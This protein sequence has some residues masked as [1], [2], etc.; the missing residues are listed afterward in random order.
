M[1]ERMS[2][3]N[4]TLPRL[5]LLAGPVLA[6]VCFLLL[7]DTYLTQSGELQEL[8]ATAR[9]VAA[10]AVLMAC[11]WMTEAIP[12]Y[13]TALVP[14]V[15]FPLF[16]ITDI[17]STAQSY[18]HEIIFLFLGGFIL[19]LAIE[20]WGLHKRL[21]LNLLASVGSRP[22]TIIGAFMA[23]AATLSM[24]VTNTATTIMLLPVAISVINLL[25]DEHRQDEIAPFGLCLLLGI[26][27]AASV[28]GMGTIVG[29][30]PNA[31]TVSFLREQGIVIGFL[32]WM[33]FGV[34]LVIVFVP[35]I[36]L[37]LTRVVFPLQ[38][39]Q[40]AGAEEMLN[41]ERDKLPPFSRAERLTLVVFVLTAALWITRPLLSKLSIGGVQPLAGLTDPGIAMLAALTLFL[42]PLDWRRG[43]FL[44]DWNT[45]V[46]LPWG[47]L[48][49]FGGGLALAAALVSSGFSAFLGAQAAALAD[50][51]LWLIVLTVTAGIVFLT[52]LTSN[53]A[54]TA[55]LIPILFAVAVGLELPPLLLVLPATFAASCAFMLP[56][57]TPPNA[58]VF[59]SGLITVP[60]MSRAGLRL[61]MAAI[62][63]VTF[64]AYA[65]L[66]PVLGVGH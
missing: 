26:A 58:I 13:A 48:L 12:V 61:N 65:I 54:T 56:V 57:A 38:R 30:A 51:P 28:G 36:W 25:P 55:T 42:M 15:L 17:R 35:L 29:T 24:W 59:G 19:A 46:K 11:W 9:I 43:V 20:K 64:A 63:L 53:T 47:L 10:L 40:L 41:A 45:A 21:A 34:P 2:G 60:Q 4:N 22:A 7:P 44:M 1:S 27:Y 18:G 31:F 39:Q 32:D 14:L 52:E 8:D 66:A 37:M 3:R 16:G 6:L 5:G 23:V 49:L 33:K 62:V 50:W